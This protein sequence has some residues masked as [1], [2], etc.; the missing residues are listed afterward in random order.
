MVVLTGLPTGV[1]LANARG[2]TPQGNPYIIVHLTN[3]ML[4][5]GKSINFTVLF[6]N[7]KKLSFQYGTSIFNV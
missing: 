2:Y 4:A 3:G 5:G 7:P 6:S 1:T